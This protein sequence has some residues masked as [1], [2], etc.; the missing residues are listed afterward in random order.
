MIYDKALFDLVPHETF[1]FSKLWILYSHFLIRHKQLD[2]AR[3]LFGQALGRCPRRKIFKAYAQLE[4]KLAQ[5]DRCRKIYERQIEVF[6]D[7]SDTWIEYAE[8]ESQLEEHERARSI[9]EV[10]INR[11]NLDMPENVW[12]AYIDMEI[13]LKSYDRVRDLYSKLLARTKH[14]KVWLSFAKFEEDSAKDAQKA[15]QVYQ[16]AS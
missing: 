4:E 16:D 6:P 8:F 12:K 10:A 13:S 2:K 11:P 14:V 1:T 9:F 15:R 5:F 7:S 3:K